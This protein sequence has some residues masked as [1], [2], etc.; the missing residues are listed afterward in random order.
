MRK[1]YGG[2]REKKRRKQKA[3]QN[4]KIS[5]ER[6]KREAKNQNLR[7]GDSEKSI[8][9]YREKSEL[10]QIAVWI[11]KSTPPSHDE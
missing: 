5:D 1:K 10:N 3:E 4:G 9:G 2:S 11:V 8:G 7:S 6:E